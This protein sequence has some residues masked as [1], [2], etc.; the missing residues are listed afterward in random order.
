MVLTRLLYLHLYRVMSNGELYSKSNTN[1]ND[2]SSPN[3]EYQ[4]MD[5]HYS[6]VQQVYKVYKY[7]KLKK[8]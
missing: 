4:L 3:Y 6:S 2:F 8:L 1:L 7:A 5:V